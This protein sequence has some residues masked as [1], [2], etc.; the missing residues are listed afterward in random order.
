MK[1]REKVRHPSRMAAVLSPRFKNMN[2]L[3]VSFTGEEGVIVR[4]CIRFLRKIR[5]RVWENLRFLFWNSHD[6]IHWKVKFIVLRS[7]RFIS[8]NKLLIIYSLF[9]SFSTILT[10]TTSINLL[11]LILYI[12]IYYWFKQRTNLKIDTRTTIYDFIPVK[13]HATNPR[14]ARR[15]SFKLFNRF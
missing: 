14:Y 1:R 9:S 6:I 2:G 7:L 13:L 5:I 4:G 3:M 11:P 10:N 8:M 15:S 12:F